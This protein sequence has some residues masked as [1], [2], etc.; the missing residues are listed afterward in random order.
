MLEKAVLLYCNP[1]EMKGDEAAWRNLGSLI[2]WIQ[3]ERIPIPVPDSEWL[4]FQRGL[5]QQVEQKTGPTKPKAA[6]AL[7]YGICMWHDAQCS[8]CK[9]PLL[10]ISGIVAMK[11]L[12]CLRVYPGVENYE[13][14]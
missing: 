3:T 12:L 4:L 1:E 5:Q 10:R 6:V 9:I 8:V 11:C 13:M 7:R 14:D 2:D